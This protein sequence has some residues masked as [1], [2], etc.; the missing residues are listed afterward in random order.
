MKLELE[1]MKTRTKFTLQRIVIDKSN[2]QASPKVIHKVGI[3]INT[4][5]IRRFQRLLKDY[6]FDNVWD[7]S[8]KNR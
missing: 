5:L 3:G 1:Y 7:E 4:H 6:M 2:Q 8:L